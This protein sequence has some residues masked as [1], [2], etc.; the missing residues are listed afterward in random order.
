V[1]EAENT[2]QRTKVQIENASQFAIQKF[3][4][5]LLDTADVLQL[6]L[7]SVNH[8]DLKDDINPPL[9]NLYTG[10]SMT[11]NQLLKTFNRHGIEA[12]DPID[13]KFD[14]NLHQALFQNAIPDKE[15]GTVFNVQKIGFTLNGRV[16]RAAQVGVVKAQE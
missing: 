1:A 16:I 5:D 8:D 15:P 13:Q 11:R 14:P 7:D 4:K 9:K 12:F 3:A 10:I 6:A 2:R